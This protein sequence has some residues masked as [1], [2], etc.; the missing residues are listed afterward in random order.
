MAI[1][2]YTIRMCSDTSQKQRALVLKHDLV[3][4]GFTNFKL[5]TPLQFDGEVGSR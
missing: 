3:L 2:K 1:H 5:V 4:F